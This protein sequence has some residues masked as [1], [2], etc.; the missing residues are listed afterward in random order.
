MTFGPDP[1]NNPE[2]VEVV[3]KFRARDFEPVGYTLYGYAAVQAWA[4][5]VEKTGS[6]ALDAVI[7]SLRSH[8]FETVLGTIGFDEKGDVT[9]S[10]YVW[11]VWENGRYVLVR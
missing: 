2:A 5:A 10:S 8:E 11:H 4:Q 1:R 3:K 6:F 9:T 7:E